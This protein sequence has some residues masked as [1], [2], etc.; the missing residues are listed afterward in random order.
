ME[1]DAWM[2][3]K[4]TCDEVP[5]L[6]ARFLPSVGFCLCF[7]MCLRF[8]LHHLSCYWSVTCWLH[9]FAVSL[10]LA[11][12][13]FVQLS[14]ILLF[15]IPCFLVLPLLITDYPCWIMIIMIV[16]FAPIKRTSSICTCFLPCSTHVPASASV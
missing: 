12:H 8:S 1:K 5:V 9:L 2:G 14:Q 7:V 11:Y 15:R 10:S 13:A 3:K 6:L 4:I 16:G